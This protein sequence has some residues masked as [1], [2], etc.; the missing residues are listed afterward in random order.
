[1]TFLNDYQPSEQERLA[2]IIEEAIAKLP[3]TLS[4]PIRKTREALADGHYGQAM[5]HMLDFYEIS[6]PFCSFLFLRLLE[7]EMD[8][9]PG[10]RPVLEDF[11]N[12]IDMK[13]PLSFG[14]WQ[15]DLLTPLLAA[16]QKFLPDHPL[17]QS[18]T[19]H[20]YVK[21]KNV[22]LG[23][24][25][26]VS[27]VQIRNEYRGHSTTLSEEIYRQVDELLEPRMLKMLEA[28]KPLTLCR[29]DIQQGRYAIDMTPLRVN[30][31]VDLY[32]LVFVNDKDYRYVFH[33]LK[34]EQA[35]Y[36]S[37]NENAV[38]YIS[39][40]MNAAIDRCL[41]HIVPSFDIA[42]DLNWSEIKKFMQ[43]QSATYLNRV[44]AEKKYN[45]EL[46]VERHKLTDTLHR[47][48]QSGAT[49][50]PLIGEAGQ[51][52]TNQLSYWTE[53][54]IA[55]DE[56]VLI[57]NASDFSAATLDITLKVIFGFN[58]RK[59]ISRLLDNVHAK[60]EATGHDVYIFFDALNECLKYADDET[61]SEGPLALYRAI[62]L[63]L[64]SHRYPRFKVLFTCRSFTWKNIVLP[65]VGDE[66]RLTFNATSEDAKVRG[67][68]HEETQRAYEIYQQLYQMRTPF[69]ELDRRVTLRLK[70]PLTLKFT[71]GIFLGKELSDN[72]NSYT[73]L[74]LYRQMANDISNSYAGN[75]QSD[76]IRLLADHITDRYL[77]R[78]A[79]DSVAVSELR[80]A[81]TDEM[82]PLHTLAQLIYK[83]DGISIA[84]AELLNKA[85]RPI[86][87]EVTRRGVRGEEKHIQFIYERYLE[88][89]M[90]C[91]FLHHQREQHGR[92]DAETFYNALQQAE[93][94]EVFIGAMRNALLEECLTAG[95][96]DTMI[97]LE[98]RWG[99]DYRV[100]S[101]VNETINT[102]IAENYEDELFDF[103]PQMMGERSE[104]ENHVI[105]EFNEV[106]KTIQ[107]NKADE[108]T[109]AR[110]KELSAI[111][112]P[113]IRLKKLASV[114][115][116]NGI[117][118][119]DYFNEGLYHHDA[120]QLLWQIMADPIYDVRNDACM[121]T[122]Y[123][124][125][126]HYT[127]DYSPLKEN[128]TVRIIKEMFGNI[129]RHNLLYNMAVGR[130]RRNTMLYVETASRLAVLMII[131][132]TLQPDQTEGEVVTDMLQEIKSI[133]RYFTVNLYLIRLFMPVFQI[134][135]R[136]QVTFQ[137]DYVN[138][139]MEYQTF[140]ID[141][142]FNNN[143]YNGVSWRQRHLKE[144]MSFCYHHTR[145][146]NNNDEAACKT[147]EERW[148]AMRDLILSAY[149]TGDS[150][151]LF[152]LERMQVIMGVSRWTN[153]EPIM[154]RFFS[155][156]F[157]QSTWFD[158]CQ[159]SMLYVL[160]QI[161]VQS[162]RPDRQL[163]EIFS[164]EAADW[165]LRCRGLFLGRRSDKA[166]SV[167]KYKRNV[168]S[169]Y[170]A[171]YCAYAADGEALE[172]DNTPVPVFYS[173]IEKAFADKDKEL[174]FHLIEN[175]QELITDMGYIKTAL[176]LI[177]Y[178]LEQLGT[179]QIIDNINQKELQRGGIY[180]YDVV[181]LIGNVF[182][183]SKNYFPAEID[184]FIQKEVV[185]LSF[186]GAKSYREDILNYHP[187]GETL[188]DVLTHKFGNF[189]MYSLLNT[190]AID[191]FS[192]EAIAAAEKSSNSFAWFE[193]CVKVLV[194]HLFGK[195]I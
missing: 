168:M 46:F 109:I 171:V 30:L 9:K 23:S 96:F 123:L 26:E 80:S 3:F 118:L 148:A 153:V 147:E 37:S 141:D 166:N 84:Y 92:V 182:S 62:C 83:Q 61:G 87:K 73:S 40:D 174:L 146:G 186:P 58:I 15:N 4:F 181:K 100:M 74:A 48:W 188:Q 175:I 114:S 90:G 157:R 2:A 50:F 94:N 122:Y 154:T 152:V 17:T 49:L 39:Y 180:Q 42:K 160:Y 184:A 158:Y 134:A 36:L 91:S 10:I 101:L 189:L 140:W 183:T 117:L 85:E 60:A 71:A 7:H 24:K 27:I 12:R 187:S 99:E 57:F 126:R 113:T 22:L 72:P 163:L 131:D 156:D 86:L 176:Q 185:G 104:D 89:V 95:S 81:F 105:N 169:W 76:I 125:N 116:V 139:A 44:Y 63:L 51:G 151:S 177:R 67:F 138:N 106:V 43:R 25:S 31:E 32:P 45:Q 149:K 54:L 142:T 5:N 178:I 159:M 133:F 52:K 155:D 135:M 128:L 56:P 98:A 172:G 164:R 108:T 121:Y 41:Q 34:D 1:M 111:L 79:I 8:D 165:T 69:S 127:L 47:F 70:D 33:T 191:R 55:A 119:T 102:L 20:I 115:I 82:S 179:Q 110:H 16:A 68:D 124:S 88:Y 38:T 129:K 35:C 64:V 14:D 59:D 13:R 161:A 190:E 65:Q 78:E 29:F 18:F 77:H 93:A 192:E 6:A 137:S 173:L 143:D 130:A 150:F 167:G 195:K 21:R 11:V 97:E 53:Q 19:S 170:A 103:I 136:R 162:E 132:D 112:A 193:H 75:R 145:Y 107:A 28:L 66:Q 194:K 120:L 144:A